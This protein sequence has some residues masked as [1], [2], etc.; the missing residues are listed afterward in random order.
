ME[1]V[2]ATRLRYFLVVVEEGHVGRAA[3]RLRIAQPSLS[4][5]IR[6]LEADIGTP[7]FRRHP[8][9]VDLTDAGLVLERE[10]RPAL[11]ALVDA[12][13]AAR[14]VAGR[15]VMRIAVSNGAFT[16][17]PA[18]AAVAEAAAGAL[19]DVEI[20]FVIALTSEAVRLVRTG[21]V[22]VAF[23][24]DPL[25]DTEVDAMPA[26]VDAPV[27][28]LPATHVLAEHA[29]LTIEAL[30]PHPILWWERDALPGTHDALVSACRR[31]GFEPRLVD[32]PDVPG[33]LGK[34]LADGVGVS[35]ISEFVARASTDP[36][37]V[38]R[39]LIR[40]RVIL[41]G[42]M[43]WSRHAPTPGAR[44]LLAALEAPTGR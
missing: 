33:V 20:E 27:V 15:Q 9:G 3:A 23:I 38:W 11:D 28:V 37:V 1:I 39:P 24:Y 16:Q 18:V 8:K 14:G 2:D 5:Q 43:I 30:A 31:A 26:F 41:N 13:R 34:M 6:R 19:G 32:V 21:S 4:Q 25:E 7:L 40:P 22:D 44:A 29:E 12:V 10:A 17:H 35:V 42:L 36:N